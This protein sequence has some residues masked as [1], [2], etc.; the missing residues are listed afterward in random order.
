[1]PA[2]MGPLGGV[3]M[4][5]DAKNDTAPTV[6]TRRRVLRNIGLA[7][8]AVPVGRLLAACGPDDGSSGDTG[9]DAGTTSDA[10]TDAG[11]TNN[12]GSW[13]TGGTAAM[14]AAS[15]YPNPFASGIGSVCN[16]TCEATLGPCYA[17]T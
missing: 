8:A 5:S 6:M 9:T 4:S 13:A 17:T 15:S 14:L 11:G 2:V 16:L 12:T 3:R 7:L 1:M 10:G